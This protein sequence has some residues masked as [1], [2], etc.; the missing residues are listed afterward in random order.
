MIDIAKTLR[1]G[2]QEDSHEFLRFFID[3]MQKGELFGKDKCGVFFP[4][5]DQD[6]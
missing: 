1:V 3:G 2:R 5:Y 4:W 6:F